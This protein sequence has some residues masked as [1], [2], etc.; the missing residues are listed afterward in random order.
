[1]RT[2]LITKE[3]I[4]SLASEYLKDSTLF[5][6]GVKISSA[7]DI[8]V[9]IDGDKG[10]SIQDCIGLSRSIENA[11]DRDKADFSLQVSSHGATTPLIM[12]RQYLKN[13]GRD[14][15]IRLQDG[16]K[17]GGRLIESDNESIT[18]EYS[19]RENKPIGKGKITVV[20]KQTIP[21]NQIKESK[22]KL[23]F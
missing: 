17:A 10:V 12:P 15:E 5:V 3:H 23:K 7:N 19:E 6:T 8:N 18:I 11:L 2:I 14:L 16:T 22:I 9:F 21:Y 4:E 1:M 20:K 13:I